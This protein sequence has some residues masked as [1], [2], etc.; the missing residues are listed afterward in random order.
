MRLLQE[1]QNLEGK[2]TE[3]LSD[4]DNTKMKILLHWCIISCLQLSVVR[5][6]YDGKESGEEKLPEHQIH[7]W[8]DLD[9][10][11]FCDVEHVATEQAHD[12]ALVAVTP[13]SKI[14]ALSNVRK[15]VLLHISSL[16][17]SN[18]TAKL[19]E[20]GKLIL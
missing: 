15:A 5:P 16:S 18:N 2:P 3:N 10:A 12:V 17:C 9:G 13:G 4:Y 11:A 20:E 8:R 19:T 1:N 6:I 7:D 14:Q